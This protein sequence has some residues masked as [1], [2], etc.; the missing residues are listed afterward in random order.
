[1]VEPFERVETPDFIKRY[2]VPKHFFGQEDA[3][4]EWMDPKQSAALFFHTESYT[5][6]KKRDCLYLFGRRGTGKTAL[7]R[8]L[9]YESNNGAER[10]NGFETT[11]VRN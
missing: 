5:E 3:S 10:V 4:A 2:S 8:M 9:D 7:I 1:V 6:F 11:A